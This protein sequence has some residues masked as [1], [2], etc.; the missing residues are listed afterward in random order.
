M[1][2]SLKKEKDTTI[3]ASAEECSE[4]KRSYAGGTFLS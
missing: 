2:R 1:S 4:E 3:V